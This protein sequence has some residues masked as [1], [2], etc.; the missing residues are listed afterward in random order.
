MCLFFFFYFLYIPIYFFCDLVQTTSRLRKHF[1]IIV[2]MCIHCLC[3][4]DRDRAEGESEH[5]SLVRSLG[6]L[7]L[8]RGRD[9]SGDESI[10][11]ESGGDD[12]D[13]RDADDETDPY[14]DDEAG[15]DEAAGS[16]G[17]GAWIARALSP[18]GRPPRSTQK[19]RG[20]RF[21]TVVNDEAHFVKNLHTLAGLAMAI[22][23]A[24][25]R[26]VVQATGTP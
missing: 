25:A 8:W 12:D 2:P 19:P 17:G 20:V 16:G 23:C 6:R 18:N 26:F 7:T 14:D 10:S 9:E 22:C 4:K 5:A 3:N 24:N 1:I 21:L 13:D 11:S 15:S